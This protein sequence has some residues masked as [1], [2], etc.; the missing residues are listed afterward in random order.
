VLPG[1]VAYYADIYGGPV[2]P[3]CHMAE[4]KLRD[5]PEPKPEDAA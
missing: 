1:N 3:E 4:W 5:K 2:C